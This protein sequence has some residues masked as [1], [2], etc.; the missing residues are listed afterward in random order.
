[1]SMPTTTCSAPVIRPPSYEGA[2]QEDEHQAHHGDDGLHDGPGFD[3]LP[4]GHPEE[5]FHEPEAGVVDVREEQRPAADRQ[6]HE[7]EV[8]YVEDRYRVPTAAPCPPG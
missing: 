5:L 4:D 8:E 2:E 1:M 6:G 7:R 3:R